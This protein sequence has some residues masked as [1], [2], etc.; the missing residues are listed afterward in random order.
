MKKY[1]LCVLALLFVNCIPNDEKGYFCAK[2]NSSYLED[3][4]E[5]SGTCGPRT[6]QILN[7]NEDGEITSD[8]APYTSCEEFTGLWKTCHS[9]ASK[10]IF[11]MDGVEVTIT[12]SIT[13]EED[14][15]G[16]SGKESFS[17]KDCSSV[18]D[19]K[20]SKIN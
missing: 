10:C 12:E 18:Y 15:H 8:Y 2:H 19:L 20:F 11:D 14:G 4:K 3:F 16:G 17:T 1:L 7:V 13:F 6:S 9:Q 5:V